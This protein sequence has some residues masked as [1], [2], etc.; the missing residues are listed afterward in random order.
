[1]LANDGGAVAFPGGAM[2]RGKASRRACAPYERC[3]WIMLRFY[4]RHIN[5]HTHTMQRSGAELQIPTAVSTVPTTTMSLLH[6]A[7][8]GDAE[9]VNLTQST[10]HHSTHSRNETVYDNDARNYRR[11]APASFSRHS[12]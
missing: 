1:M 9:E 6:T 12:L 10:A 2:V 3:F 11:E 5:I 7:K 4:E 8:R